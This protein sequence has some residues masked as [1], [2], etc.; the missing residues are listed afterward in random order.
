MI[1]P[2][3]LKQTYY[4]QYYQTFNKP[5]CEKVKHNIQI[6]LLNHNKINIIS[7]IINIAFISKMLIV[8]NYHKGT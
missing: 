7:K 2:A 6:R 5:T 4:Y 8:N 3:G 1:S